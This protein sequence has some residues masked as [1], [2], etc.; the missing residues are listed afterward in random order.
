MATSDIKN[1]TD[2]VKVR[3]WSKVN[4]QS[5][6]ACWEWMA[7]KAHFG[8]GQFWFYWRGKHGTMVEAHR[9][10]WLICVGEVPAGKCVLHTCDNPGCVRISHLYIG[11]KKQNAIDR[12]D[13][14]RH[15]KDR[16]PKAFSIHQRRISILGNQANRA[17]FE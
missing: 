5:G 17:R 8:H 15:W 2:D 16:D 11:T 1:L 7:S 10:S 6:D 14:R 4:K 9:V 3:F 12:R 13:R